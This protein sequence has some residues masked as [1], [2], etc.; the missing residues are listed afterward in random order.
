MRTITLTQ[1]RRRTSFWVYA[2][3]A[4]PIVITIRGQPSVLLK[5]DPSLVAASASKPISPSPKSK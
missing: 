1:L 3:R 4:E 5:H 2:S